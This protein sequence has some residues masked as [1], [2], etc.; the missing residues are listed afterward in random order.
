MFVFSSLNLWFGVFDALG[1]ARL[2]YFFVNSTTATEYTPQSP[3][4]GK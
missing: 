4:N 3:D 2:R 1:D